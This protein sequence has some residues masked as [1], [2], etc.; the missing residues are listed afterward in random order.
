[1]NKQEFELLLESCR[2]E[3][4]DGKDLVDILRDYPDWAE[5]LE[6]LL[7]AM[8]LTQS[9]PRPEAS[10]AAMIRG[11]NRLLYELDEKKKRGFFLNFG[12]IFG[13][14]RYS[15]RRKEINGDLLVGKENNEMKFLPR[16]A[17]YMI[18][19]VLIGGFFTVNASASSLPGDPLYGLKLNW[20]EFQKM[21]ALSEEAKLELEFEFDQER[22]EEIE[23]LLEDGRIEKVEFSGLVEEKGETAWLVGGIMV[24][25]DSETEIYGLIEIGDQVEVEAI[26][27]EDGF[28]LAIEIHLE[29]SSDEDDMSDDMD[30]DL[31]DDY[32]DDMDDDLDDD[33][34]DDMDDDMDDDLD[35][36]HDDEM[37]GDMV[38]DLE[39]TE[40]FG[41]V[42]SMNTDYLVVNEKIVYIGVDT[43]IES[44]VM[45]GS[46]VEVEAWIQLD[47]TYLGKDIDLDDNAYDGDDEMELTEF[48][49]QVESMNT[50]Y[51]VVSGKM[52]Y[53]GT[54][55]DIE[56]EIIVGSY[57]EVEAWIQ[58]D[59]TYLGKDIDLD[60]N[61]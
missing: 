45:V 55:T 44:E 18:V 46:Y 52:V 14:L 57:V 48:F 16:L 58:S 1:M 39:L 60:D 29:D 61:S 54:D 59:G 30:D 12:T 9:L 15:G 6:P 33:H 11:K 23:I 41:Q 51:L 25:I 47:G 22:L 36:D 13:F 7:Q 49:G 38:D 20:E 56:P 26:T 35:D 5:E 32:D 34:D 27:Q 3:L 28:L 2:Q 43:D 8:V 50:D 19:T 53:I 24:F 21:L 40:F 31:D 10:Q 4:M 37:D 42:E 17:I